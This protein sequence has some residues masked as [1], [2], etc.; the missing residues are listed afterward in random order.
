[1]K[2]KKFNQ[3]VNENLSSVDDLSVIMNHVHENIPSKDIPLL[4]KEI[5][6]LKETNESL[7]EGF[8]SDIKD[9]LVRWFDDRMMN[10]LVNKK[11]DFYSELCD[12]LK[13]YDLTT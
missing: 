4:L 12:K 10:R 9:K 3:F 7:K 8:F 13:K 1:M 2:L 6:N 11:K 5:E